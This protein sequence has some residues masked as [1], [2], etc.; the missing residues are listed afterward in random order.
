[1]N[2]IMI[3]IVEERMSDAFLKSHLK[4]LPF[5][6]VLHHFTSISDEI[7]DHPFGFTSHILFGGYVERVYTFDAHGVWWSQLIHR[8][9]GTVHSVEATHIHQIV[10]LP[11]GECYTLII[12]QEKVRE[13]RFWKFDENGSKSRA[14]Y[15][16]DFE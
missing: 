14:W 15:E 9:Q 13:T 4:G 16:G 7:H 6:A 12:P 2:E 11:I 8:K 10:D 3:T 5:D 1:M